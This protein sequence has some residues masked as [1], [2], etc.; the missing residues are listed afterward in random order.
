MDFYRKAVRC[1]YVDLARGTIDRGIVGTP[2]GGTMSPILSNIMLHELDHW[3][4][5]QFVEPSKVTGKTS[6]PNPEYVKVH[7]KI[8]NLRQYFLPSYR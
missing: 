1:E 8:S 5:V 7:T 3:L 4:N 6:I 2:Q